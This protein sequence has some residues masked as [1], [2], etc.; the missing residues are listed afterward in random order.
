[1]LN[2]AL[3]N[4]LNM[5]YVD[6]VEQDSGMN[7]PIL[8]CLMAPAVFSAGI[9]QAGSLLRIREHLFSYCVSSPSLLNGFTWILANK[10][11]GTRS[12]V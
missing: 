9:Q 7:S 8:V 12:L 5:T 1:M 11:T 6:H 3:Y 4:M 2:M 10:V